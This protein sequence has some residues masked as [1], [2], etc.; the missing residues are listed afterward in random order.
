MAKFTDGAYDPT[1]RDGTIPKNIF[2]FIL[3][4]FRILLELVLPYSNPTLQR[5]EQLA[6]G[7][8]GSNYTVF[9]SNETQ[10]VVLF[11][12]DIFVANGKGI[13]TFLFGFPMNSAG[14]LYYTFRS[15]TMKKFNTG[16]R[17]TMQVF[18]LLFFTN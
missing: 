5:N 9:V 8:L 11:F 10:F 15:G 7:S 3:I 14:N 2:V 13:L 1:T 4:F 16:R 6:T 17:T 18:S 12:V